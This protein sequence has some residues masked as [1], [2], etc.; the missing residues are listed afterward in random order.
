MANETLDTSTVV[1]NQDIPQTI[2]E[3]LLRTTEVIDKDISQTL[4][5]T[6][7]RT[8][9]VLDKDIPQTIQETNLSVTAV[10]GQVGE[11]VQTGIVAT[12]LVIGKSLNGIFNNFGVIKISVPNSQIII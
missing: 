10:L 12:G 9:S 4:Q 1:V 3:T 11:K 6:I 7:V 2:Q 5:E 8:T